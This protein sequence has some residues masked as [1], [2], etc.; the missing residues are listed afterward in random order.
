MRLHVSTSHAQIWSPA[1]AWEKEHVRTHIGDIQRSNIYWH[2]PLSSSPVLCG[3]LPPTKCNYNLHPFH[4]FPYPLLI[5]CRELINCSFVARLTSWTP[6]N[7]LAL[8]HWLNLAYPD[9]LSR[10]WLSRAA[11]TVNG[12]GVV[13]IVKQEVSVLLELTWLFSLWLRHLYIDRHP[14]HTYISL[15]FYSLAQSICYFIWYHINIF[16]PLLSF[17]FT[18]CLKKSHLWQLE[19][20]S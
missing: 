1:C 15:C 9:L 12:I 16:V 11:C 3:L 17:G 10:L 19:G 6:N 5:G 2:L 8:T 4:F 7:K 18:C 14:T 20:I 13:C